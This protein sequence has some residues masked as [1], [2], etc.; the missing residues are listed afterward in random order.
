MFAPADVQN[1]ASEGVPTPEWAPVGTYSEWAPTN[2]PLTRAFLANEPGVPRVPRERVRRYSPAQS[3]CEHPDLPDYDAVL[4]KVIRTVKYCD[5]FSLRAPWRGTIEPLLLGGLT[6]AEVL[7]FAWEQ[8]HDLHDDPDGPAMVWA[9]IQRARSMGVTTPSPTDE[10]P[11]HLLA[12]TER[13]SLGTTWLD[14]FA[15]YAASAAPDVPEPFRRAMAWAVLSELL[16]AHLRVTL[17]V[18]TVLT[19]ITVVLAGANRPTRGEALR[20]G[21]SSAESLPAS[22][23]QPRPNALIA[24]APDNDLSAGALRERQVFDDPTSSREYVALLAE[25]QDALEAAQARL[26]AEPVIVADDAALARI[27]ALK[28]HLATR[29]GTVPPDTVESVVSEIAGLVRRMA[30][31]VAVVERAE[32]VGVEHVL[33]TIQ[34]AEGTIELAVTQYEPQLL[35]AAQSRV[36]RVGS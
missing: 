30:T 21:A 35:L 12:E 9:E 11:A 1:A 33:A 28:A 3:Q 19:S 16:G 27:T 25:G 31:L 26:G 15:D 2:R 8:A 7:A 6:D 36:A 5:A 18:D 4:A 22:R 24:S 34:A 29:L 13:V 17:G 14:R 23:L 20:L 10:P 32:R